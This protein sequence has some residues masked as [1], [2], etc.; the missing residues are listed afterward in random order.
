MSEQNIDINEIYRP[1]VA[2]GNQAKAERALSAPF[3]IVSTTKFLLLFVATLGIYQLVWFYKHWREYAPYGR[4]AISPFWRAIFAIFFTH[5]LFRA[6]EEH[7][8]Y[9]GR[10]SAWSPQGMATLFVGLT[11][12]AR[13]AD[14]V[15]TSSAELG[16]EDLA[17]FILT[18]STGVPLVVAQ[19]A[20]NTACGDPEGKTNSRLTLLNW[21]FVCVGGLFWF[22]VIGSFLV[23]VQ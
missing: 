17:A 8:N 9:S 3:Y 5:A 16:A 19:R 6:F 15:S 7:G 21:V 11:I 13:I 10:P 22:L 12:V 4:K 23:P 14:R 20:C 1:P 18:L 2:A